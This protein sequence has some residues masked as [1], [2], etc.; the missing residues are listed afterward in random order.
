MSTHV[1]DSTLASQAQGGDLAA[2]EAL[3]Q[4][5]RDAVYGLC[6]RLLGSQADAAEVT[7]ETF[8]TAYRKLADFRGESSFA[9]WLHRIA[10]NFALMR[11]RH[12]KV[13]AE[14]DGAGSEGQPEFNSRG[15]LLDEV[16]DWSRSALD[17]TLDAELR[18]AIE[19]G[20]DKLPKDLKEV[21]VL[22]DL[23]GLSY[24]DVALATGL[25]LPAM[26]SRLHRARLAL[27]A[28]IDAFYAEQTDG[29]GGPR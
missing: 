14:V 26:K 3:V 13:A 28:A 29:P 22:R 9:T 2:F 11:L 25:S 21:F 1:D 24:E 20:V 18:D 16:A 7:Q 6:V 19:K 5:H 23:E 27:R 12:R 8:L 10:T 4:R 17:L 15:T